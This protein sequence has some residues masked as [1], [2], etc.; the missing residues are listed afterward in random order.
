MYENL[1]NFLVEN[2]SEPCI[3]RVFVLWA[4]DAELTRSC[5]WSSDMSVIARSRLQE[6]LRRIKRNQE[7]PHAPPPPKKP[8]KKK[9]TAVLLKVRPRYLCR[10]PPPHPHPLL[11][12]SGIEMPDQ[13]G[14]CYRHLLTL[15][16]VFYESNTEGFRIM[17]ICFTFV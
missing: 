14:Q 13:N 10:H 5:S 4:A 17:F 16:A 1:R 3:K 7:K 9:E 15:F 6:Q 12:P 8:K 2:V 11:P